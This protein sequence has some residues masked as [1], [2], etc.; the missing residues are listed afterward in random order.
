MTLP[1]E[2][3]CKKSERAR[4]CTPLRN[5]PRSSNCSATASITSRYLLSASLTIASD[6]GREAATPSSS[7]RRRRAAA[8]PVSTRRARV[9]QSVQEVVGARRRGEE[10]RLLAP[11]VGDALDEL[12]LTRR[13]DQPLATLKVVVERANRHPGALGDVCQTEVRLP[14]FVQDLGHHRERSLDGLSTPRPVRRVPNRC[15][16]RCVMFFTLPRIVVCC[17]S[18]ATLRQT[19]AR[20]GRM[21]RAARPGAARQAGDVRPS[22]VTDLTHDWNGF[23]CCGATALRAGASSVTGRHRPVTC[24]TG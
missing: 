13:P 7:R 10:R 16:S 22:P 23:P 3:M 8:A 11:V 9:H 1:I 15:C 14:P 5:H 2:L 20:R 17:T 21:P 4:G 24:P 19:S 18:H 6:S 12:A